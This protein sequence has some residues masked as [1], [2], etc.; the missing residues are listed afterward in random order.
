MSEKL[1]EI[2]HHSQTVK[3]SIRGILCLNNL[4]FPSQELPGAMKQQGVTLLL[5]AM[6]R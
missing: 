3:H 1:S 2:A 6:M 5:S 4:V